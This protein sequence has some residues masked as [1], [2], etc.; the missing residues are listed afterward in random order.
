M[1]GGASSPAGW[2]PGPGRTQQTRE[3]WTQ[4]PGSGG[5]VA[6]CGPQTLLLGTDPALPLHRGLP[7][8]STGVPTYGHHSLPC[9]RACVSTSVSHARMALS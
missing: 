5:A 8:A 6:F 3:Q 7:R 2:Q 4:C 9:A 1:R